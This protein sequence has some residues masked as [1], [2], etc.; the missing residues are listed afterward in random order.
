MAE[1]SEKADGVSIKKP[2]GFKFK[3]LFNLRRS[4]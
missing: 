3:H 4:I 1:A 2:T